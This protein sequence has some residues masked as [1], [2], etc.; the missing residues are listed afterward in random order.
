MLLRQHQ[1][2]PCAIAARAPPTCESANPEFPAA[3]A[4][5]PCG[6]SRKELLSLDD[7]DGHD[8]ED[9]LKEQKE[10]CGAPA[11]VEEPA[12]DAEQ[13]SPMQRRIAGL[14]ANPMMQRRLAARIDVHVRLG[15][16]K[17]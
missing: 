11:Q 8:E 14:Q 10:P 9:P 6:L 2:G 15:Q 5:S 1:K 12:E 16:R 17:V 13:M 3:A 7:D 4:T